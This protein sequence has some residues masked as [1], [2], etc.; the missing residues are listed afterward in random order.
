[1]PGCPLSVTREPLR[2][3]SAGREKDL[4]VDDA[5]EQAVIPGK[6]RIRFADAGGMCAIQ[7]ISSSGRVRGVYGSISGSV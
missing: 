1:M 4:G 3:S 5:L 2:E 7:S 6:G